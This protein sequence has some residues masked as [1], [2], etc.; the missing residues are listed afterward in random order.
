MKCVH[1]KGRRCKGGWVVRVP[2]W[3]CLS[4]RVCWQTRTEWKDGDHGEEIG[5][6]HA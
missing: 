5:M 3:R 6:T 1:G 4:L 2:E